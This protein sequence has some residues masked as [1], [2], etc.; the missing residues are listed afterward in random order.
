M[1]ATLV[2]AIEAIP[3][4]AMV[5]TLAEAMEDTLVE[6]TE[7]VVTPGEGTRAEVTLVEDT[8]VTLAE[9]TLG[10]AVATVDAADVDTMEVANA[11]PQ[12]TRCPILSTWRSL[13]TRG[14]A[15]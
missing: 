8:G 15:M 1:V 5:A 13:V 7:E 3:E 6:G 9:D 12:P 4:E 10:V 14:K 2:V 11:A